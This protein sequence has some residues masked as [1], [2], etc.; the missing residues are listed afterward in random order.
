MSSFALDPRWRGHPAPWLLVASFALNVAALF[1]PFMDLRQGLSTEPYT[2]FTTIEFLWDS[3]LYVLAAVVVAFSV[4]FPFAKLGV[5]ASIL[6]SRTE[7][8][9]GHA[10]LE[11]VERCGK[12]SMLDVFLVALMI[13]L[14]NDQLLVAAAPRAGIVCFSLAIAL[15]LVC[16]GTMLARLDGRTELAPLRIRSSRWPALAQVALLALLVAAW[17]VP[18]L[19]IDDWLLADRPVSIAGAIADLWDANA[20]SLAFVMLVALVLAPLASGCMALGAL[21]GKP[22]AESTSALRRALGWT[23]HWEMLD[24]FAVALGIFLVEGRSFVRTELSWGAFLIALLLALYWPA[25]SL[26]YRRLAPH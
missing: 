7:R 20:K 19:E 5:L 2:L 11:V 6:V 10:L 3:K 25:S 23:R 1:L 18:F 26:Y 13:T 16:S 14:A 8:E 24:V 17:F 22:D 9:R 15:S 21:L 4:C 12:W